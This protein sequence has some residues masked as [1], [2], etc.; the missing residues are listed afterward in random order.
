MQAGEEF[1]RHALPVHDEPCDAGVLHLLLIAR[2]E[3]GHSHREMLVPAMGGH[4]QGMALLV[5]QQQERS[6][7]QNH[8]Q[9]PDQ[10]A[11][12]EHLTVDRLAVSIHIAGQRVGLFGFSW[13]LGWMPELCGPTREGIGEAFSAIGTGDLR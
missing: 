11:W 3:Y 5:V 2:Q 12:D 7:A 8:A 4:T 6:A 10:S 13:V 1:G 9:T